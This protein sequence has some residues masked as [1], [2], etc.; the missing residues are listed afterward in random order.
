MDR[1]PPITVSNIPSQWNRITEFIVQLTAV[2]YADTIHDTPSG[3][4]KTYYTTDGS[5]PNTSSPHGPTD[6]GDITKFTLSGQGE[7]VVKFF[8]V[9]N[10]GNTER[11]KEATLKLDNVAPVTSYNVSFSPDGENGW[12]K[13][14][15]VITLSSIDT[16]SGIKRI[17][18]R[19]N[20][21]P[22]QEYLSSFQIPSH[23]V[24]TLEYYAED[25][26]GNVENLKVAFFKLDNDIPETQDDAPS[27]IQ[28][29][30]TTVSF[31]TSDMTS[32]VANT[33]YTTDG[34]IPTTSSTSGNSVAFVETGVYTIKY[35]SVDFAGNQEP[36]KT[37]Q[38]ELFIDIE[39][40]H[41][42]VSESFPINGTNGWY[43]TSP[44]ISLSAVDP[45][46]IKEIQYRLFPPDQTTTAKYNS[47][48]DISS[49]VDMGTDF[50]IRLEVDQSG[51]PIEISLKGSVPE[52]TTIV[53]VINAINTAVG[54]TIAT[55]TGPDG[56]IGYGYV[57]LTSPTAGSGSASSEIKFLKPL[58]N[59]ITN[60]VFGLDESSYPHVFTETVV[61]VPYTSPISMP[62]DGLWRIDYYAEDNA[63]N[64]GE[65]GTKQYK[66]DSE[67]PETIIINSFD[68]DGDNGWY[69]TNPEITFEPQDN[70][71]GIYK[72]FFQWDNGIIVEFSTGTI[73]NIPSEGVHVL[74]VYS[75]DLAGNIE[76]QQNVEYKL[77]QTQPVTTDD[78]LFYQGVIFTAKGSGY[79]VVTEENSDVIGSYLIETRNQNVASVT[80]VYNITKTQEYSAYKISGLEKNEIE[81]YPIVRNENS[82]RIGP[83]EIRLFVPSGSA[84]KQTIRVYNTKNGEV[85]LASDYNNITKHAILSGTK[86]IEIGDI[87]EVEYLYTGPS[88][89]LGDILEVSYTYDISHDPQTLNT[90]NYTLNESINQPYI[91]DHDVTIR[92]YP[93]DAISSVV[94]TYYTIDGSDPTTESPQGT[95]INLTDSGFYTIKYFSID[96]AGNIEDIKTAQY[97]IVI[98]KKIPELE[99]TILPDP[100]EDGENGWFK[101]NFRVQV[102]IWSTDFVDR[103]GEEAN[104]ATTHRIVAGINDTIDFEETSGTELTATIP[105]GIY[106]SQNLALKIQEV[107]N[108]AGDSNYNVS[109]I[110][111]SL[112]EGQLFVFISDLSG[113]D[114]LFNLLWASGT[115][116]LQTVAVTIGCGSNNPEFMTFDFTGSDSY[117]S[118]Y[119][120]LRL[121]NFFI[122]SV[123]QIRTSASNEQLALVEILN[124]PQGFFNEILVLGALPQPAIITETINIGEDVSEGTNYGFI[125]QLPIITGSLSVT[126][127]GTLLL[128][129][130]YTFSAEDGKIELSDDSFLQSDIF[131]ATY[132]LSD[133]VLV[134]YTHY[135]GI[136]KVNFGLDTISLTT[137]VQVYND[138][139]K[140]L[141]LSNDRANFRIV[142][143]STSGQF[144]LQEG[145]HTIFARAYDHNSVAGTGAP[146]KLSSLSDLGFQ[147]DRIV[148]IT[149]DNVTSS[150][151]RK[152]PVTV[153]LIPYDHPSGSGIAET[154]YT[155]DGSNPTRLSPDATEIDF[156]ISGTFIL[157]YFSVDFA[158][159]QESVKTALYPIYVDANAPVTSIFTSPAAPDGD[160]WWFKSQPTIGFSTIDIHSGT[161]KTFYKINDAEFF[162]EYT[163]PFLLTEQG[164]VRITFYSIDNVGNVEE[165]KV[166]IIKYDSVAPSTST[167]IPSGYTSNPVVE[168]IVTDVSSGGRTTYYTINGVDPD[169]N[170]PHGDS[171]EFHTSGTFLLKFFSIDYAGNV[172]TIKSQ[173]VYFDLEA[174]EI[175]D[176]LPV[177]CIVDETTTEIS[178]K[179][180]DSLSGVDINAISVDVDGVI[181]SKQKNSSYF[182]YTGTPSEYHIRIFPIDG[183]LNFQD[184]EVLRVRDVK[185]FAGNSAPLLEYNFTKQD[186]SAPWVREV[187]PAPN[188]QDVSTN[189]NVIAF[190]DDDISGVDIKSVQIKINGI[191][192]KINSRNILRV[193]YLG[194]AESAKLQIYNRTLTTF[195][196]GIRDIYISLFDANYST[197]KKVEQYFNSL[198]DYS[199]EI[200][201]TRFEQKESTL[202]LNVPSL[203]I[204]IPNILDL[205][206]PDENL[207]FSFIERGNGYLVFANPNFNFEHKV[208]V[209]VEISAQDNAGN[210]MEVF[211]YLF[212]PHIYATPSV[213]K[214]N[215]LNR[216]ALEYI[217]DIQENI[218]SNYSRSKST[219]FYGHQK[220]I[221]LELAR[222]LEEIDHLNEDRDYDTLRPVNL[223]NKLG[224]MLETKP[225]IGLSHDDYRRML[226]SLIS[227]F[228]KGSLKSS[229][230]EGVELFTGS[231]VQIIE[232]VFS[233]G[234]D[235]SQQFVF[236][237]DIVL[238]ENRILGLDLLALS[239]NLKHIFDLVKPAH[240]F[241]IQRFVWTEHFE[242]QA[243]C[244]LK[245]LQDQFGNYVLDQFGNKI[246][247]IASDGFQA[248]ETNS[249]TAICDRDKFHFKNTLEEDVREDCN[250]KLAKIETYIEDV[251][252]QFTGIEDFFYTYRWPLLK[253]S[254]EVAST[255][256]VIV[257]VDDVQVNV[258]E[259][260]PLNG[261]V[262]IDLVPAFGSTVVVTYKYNQYFVYREVS[263]YLNDYSISGNDFIQDVG[264]IFNKENVYEVFGGIQIPDYTLELHA[265]VCET[266]LKFYLKNVYGDI[267]EVPECNDRRFF[268]LNDYAVEGVEFVDEK[269]SYLNNNAVGNRSTTCPLL[270]VTIEDKQEEYIE[271]PKEVLPSMILDGRD[272]GFTSDEYYF[273]TYR[274][275]LFGTSETCLLNDPRLVLQG[276]AAIPGQPHA[277]DMG[278]KT[279][280]QKYTHYFLT[281]DSASKFDFH[282][283]VD[284]YDEIEQ[285]EDER[286]IYLTDKHQDQI[287][288]PQEVTSSVFEDKETDRYCQDNFRFNL[289]ENSDQGILNDPEFSLLGR[290]ADTGDKTVKNRYSENLLTLDSTTNFDFHTG[291]S[292]SESPK[293][294][295]FFDPI[296][297]NDTDTILNNEN[298][299]LYGNHIDDE[300]YDFDILD[301]QVET[302][303][304]PKEQKLDFSQLLN[305]EINSQIEDKTT[306]ISISGEFTSDRVVALS[307]TFVLND[308][309]PVPYV[310]FILNE[311]ILNLG[312]ELGS[313]NNYI[314]NSILNNPVYLLNSSQSEKVSF[315]ITNTEQPIEELKEHV[316]FQTTYKETVALGKSIILNDNNSI[317]NEP[318]QL[319]TQGDIDSCIGYGLA[320]S[321]DIRTQLK[322]N[323]FTLN[324]IES[325][326]NTTDDKLLTDYILND[327]LI[328]LDLEI[329]ES[330]ELEQPE[331]SLSFTTAF[332]EIVTWGKSFVLN[333]IDSVLNG[334][335][336]L[337]T[338]DDICV[339]MGLTFKEELQS[340]VLNESLLNSEDLLGYSLVDEKLVN[341]ALT[342][343]EQETKDIIDEE[344]FRVDFTDSIRQ[345]HYFYLYGGTDDPGILNNAND[346]LNDEHIKDKATVWMTVP[347][348]RLSP[349]LLPGV[350]NNQTVLLN[351]VN[352]INYMI[353]S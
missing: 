326:L 17:F 114:G 232:I 278:E 184:I 123:E 44:Q 284:H 10:A 260:N 263:F 112:S 195:I 94:K 267:Y 174:P 183:L 160:N 296:I 319:L 76:S 46:G 302:I 54:Q 325:T 53:E 264:S 240:V 298:N 214:R 236:T 169:F 335:T 209:N 55:E 148:P 149:T 74:H 268:Y 109:L 118:I 92:L 201:D 129:S 45:S 57:T 292:F 39:A 221:S 138:P 301:K 339:S 175:F 144:F 82:E 116:A 110:D 30:A 309:V 244:T 52:Q 68:P 130:E 306:T 37:S 282:F 205:Y 85:Y 294:H 314:P 222:H 12:Y 220:A 171:I 191:D 283:G 349:D 202:L 275:E 346:W 140:F 19:W 297:L 133:K 198:P 15:P 315:E 4:D 139:D 193:Q 223:Y 43:R 348:F 113:G 305:D 338:Q 190:I 200:L 262:K 101:R 295:L 177:D 24:H 343:T 287:E 337:N 156:D 289:A 219:N 20:T 197:I 344:A 293:Q 207:N 145:S 168:F 307:N 142:F 65:T 308:V 11:T 247:I 35:F 137:S 106:T 316:D 108:E 78:T 58:S 86:P 70:L 119:Y 48:E 248:A 271:Q 2:D 230:E 62:F 81:V 341:I 95:V 42:Y 89:S 351:S 90:L 117:F 5:E 250:E 228:F 75:I 226:Q 215:Y 50:F 313:G 132:Q 181:Y 161:Q 25:N 245:W 3:V 31:F 332:E 8:S 105:A 255:E 350:L 229:L 136:D 241:I 303:E 170:S 224:Y 146:Q 67:A 154:H 259:V 328:E 227:I 196:D 212:I 13:I 77:D 163:T 60:E 234:S 180:K 151:W 41:T 141:D 242:F 71:S 318:T 353:D 216:V 166:A 134:D 270:F 251:S 347:E 126:K 36:I 107:L 231:D 14:N 329:P 115:H 178:F 88:L 61:F 40:P 172:E 211:K 273:D 237:A 290:H 340:F 111:S 254:D 320:L 324:N 147:L 179:V 159:N 9:D 189:S 120:K 265:H 100:L 333:D 131:V 238:G 167:N 47:T 327:N 274:F 322:F 32:G 128:P 127:N 84:F 173:I 124:G 164:E 281:Q 311:S 288:I 243:G 299:R 16:S 158:G 73:T 125:S 33:Y 342:N 213:K 6:S 300:N 64:K 352:V 121:N 317:L 235:I 1:T 321:E 249:S 26:A 97:E 310:N 91:L 153:S 272:N 210:L 225:Y 21:N 72:T 69:L 182:L 253:D 285:P 27:G 155:I 199:A 23:G 323:L 252:I 345:R 334:E 80:Y 38:V 28:K 176:F 203:D 277:G 246:P 280:E 206:I 135:I 188:A 258:V 165:E 185:D 330:E 261:Y 217:N 122:K 99:M 266:F 104:E 63:G 7:F 83:Y 103:Q 256:D 51:N 66:L 157:K 218:A 304:E 18:Y 187:Y 56:S 331:E 93:V 336:E 143:P 29:Q 204:L 208:P 22:F 34:S 239:D 186:D 87:L 102:D 194:P 276:R 192:F 96:A 152:A 279:T 79:Q 291:M 233:E 312:D 59:D 49:T 286:E 257:T 150:T 269:G 162:T 98:D